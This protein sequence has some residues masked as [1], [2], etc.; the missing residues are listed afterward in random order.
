MAAR[1]LPDPAHFRD[2]GFA[3][4]PSDVH[5]TGDGDDHGSC[6]FWSRFPILAGSFFG[7]HRADHH[8][9]YPS[10]AARGSAGELRHRRCYPDRHARRVLFA[11]QC[12]R[13]ALGRIDLGQPEVGLTAAAAI[14]L[15]HRHGLTCDTYGFASTPARLDPQFAYERLA[16]AIVPA[17]AGGDLLSG[18]GVLENNMAVSLQ[19]AVIDDEIISIIKHIAKGIEVNKDTLAFDL[20]KEVIPMHGAFLSELHTVRHMRGGAIWMPASGKRAT[21]RMTGQGGVLASASA[22]AK[23]LLASHRVDPLPDGTLRQLDDILAEAR[24]ELVP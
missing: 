8:G 10:V 22:R 6:P 2:H 14:Q 9:R 21:P 4:E 18:V 23:D 24:R 12:H 1:R 3:G 13:H 16:N 11:R 17:L 19:A 5:G 15:A 7:G 20:M